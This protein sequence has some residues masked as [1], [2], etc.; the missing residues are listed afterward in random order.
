MTN[1]ETEYL[2]QDLPETVDALEETNNEQPTEEA[3]ATSFEEILTNPVLLSKIAELGFTTPTPVQAR[4]I[5]SAVEGRNLLVQAKTGSGK[6]LSFSLPLLNHVQNL[7]AERNINHT[8]A[9]VLSPTRELALQIKEVIAKISPWG[10]PPCLIGGQDISKQIDALKDEPKIVIGTPG[11]VLD[12][13]RQRVLFLGKCT[14]CVLDEADEMLSMGFLEDVR[15]ILSR[16]PDKRQ[17]LFVSATITPRVEMLAHSFLSKPERIIVD[18]PK[19]DL[20]PIEHCYCEVGGDLMAKPQALCDLLETLRP[21]SAIIFCNT[22]S[23][24]QLVEA[25]LRRRGF[26]ARRIN[27]DLT[28]KQRDRVMA[29]IRKGDLQFLVATDIAAR[30]LDMEQIDL[31]V[32]YAVHDDPE[33]YV[34]RTGRT[35]RAGRSG[36]AVSIVSPKDFGAFHFL[37]KVVNADFKKI[38][39]PT[40]SEVAD[41]RLAHLYEILREAKLEIKTRDEIVAAKLLTDLGDIA[42]PSDEFKSIVAKLCRHAVEH[43]IAHEAT[44]LDEEL[45]AAAS[46]DEAEHAEESER[47][48]RRKDR[49]SSRG[50]KQRRDRRSHDDESESSGERRHAGEHP[51]GDRRR[52][53]SHGDEDR[54]ENNHRENNHREDNHGEERRGRERRERDPEN[55]DS[56]RSQRRDNNDE[57]RPRRQESRNQE[58]RDDQDNSREHNSNR[59]SYD[60]QSDNGNSDE[61]RLY[62]GQGF[63]HGMTSDVFCAMAADLANIRSRD[64]R[65]LSLRDYYGFVDIR[66][67]QAHALMDALNGIEHNGEPLSIEFATVIGSVPPARH[68]NRSRDDRGREQR[69]RGRDSRGRDN[70]GRNNRRDGDDRGRGRRERRR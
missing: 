60:R 58:H 39:L 52:K 14:F 44:A 23:D 38:E 10:S 42:D 34:H 41:A 32:N 59:N 64:L 12:C 21:R 65:K 5:P 49:D 2:D 54:R 29:K 53:E 16:L 30:G 1:E 27:S 17:G 3:L 31:V 70:R 47:R 24:T 45:A 8:C 46:K 9:L 20:P 28:Q 69:G 4:T 18:R 15:A 7:E 67:D 35:G 56:R 57:Q 26:D 11:R 43:F 48:G 19:E 66:R 33:S 51:R 68:H 6:T 63:T 37:T 55:Q 40:D 36:K 22:K 25:L 62:I 61:I 50:D 13:L